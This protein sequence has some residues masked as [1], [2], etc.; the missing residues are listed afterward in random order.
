MATFHW[1]DSK[2]L[3]FHGHYPDEAAGVLE[4]ARAAG[5]RTRALLRAQADPA[6]VA[7]LGGE[8]L[9]TIRLPAGSGDP[10]VGAVDRFFAQAQVFEQVWSRLVAG[11]FARDDMLVVS[12]VEPGEAVGLVRALARLAP[13]ASP[14][15]VMR[16][17]SG[18]FL[19]GSEPAAFRAPAAEWRTALHL[20]GGQLPRIAVTADTPGLAAAMSGLFDRRVHELPPPLGWSGPV[21]PRPPGVPSRRERRVLMI[22]NSRILAWPDVVAAALGIAAMPGVTLRVKAHLP[23]RWD[24]GL[25]GDLAGHPDITVVDRYL[26]HAAH[27]EEFATADLLVLPATLDAYRF[28]SSGVFVEAAGYGVPAVVPE[29]SWMVGE[30]ARGRAVAVPFAPAT[31]DAIVAAAAR[32]LGDLDGLAAEARR[33]ADIA[34]ARFGRAG[35]LARLVALSRLDPDA[36]ARREAS[37]SDATIRFDRTGDGGRFLRNGWAAADTAGV[38]FAAA[39]AAL[40]FH[41]DDPPHRDLPIAFELVLPGQAADPVQ[42][43][44]HAGGRPVA[45][46]SIR[47]GM[48]RRYALA[49][50][51]GLIRDGILDLELTV[52][53]PS[54]GPLKVTPTLRRLHLGAAAEGAETSVRA[55]MQG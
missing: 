27:L 31:P 45:R 40:R 28:Q 15:T 36:H 20:L 13:A 2:L 46:G 26:P 8:T 30:A 49:V 29:G 12:S 35:F 33:C 53:S 51:V 23:Q 22:L 10:L 44:V 16:M 39:R 25:L 41:L 50:P 48:A 32:A 24:H 18:R 55:G 3:R 47:P 38:C 42:V 34:R 21:R 5:F 17:G 4:A 37:S 43:V 52:G 14:F 54:G 9:P 6:L 11:R 7:A 19:L 1:Y